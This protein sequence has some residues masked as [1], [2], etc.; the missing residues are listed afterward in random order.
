MPGGRG[1]SVS[2]FG[3]SGFRFS[4]LGCWLLGAGFVGSFF[5]QDVPGSS[6]PL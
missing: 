4:A 2:A 6:E 1:G 5:F 3:S